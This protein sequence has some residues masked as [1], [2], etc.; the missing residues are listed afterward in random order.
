[1]HKSLD[2]YKPAAAARTH[3]LLAALMWTVVGGSLL[4]VGA[5]W[6]LHAQLAI[7]LPLLA[8]ALTAG[9]L[10]ARFVLRRTSARMIERIRVRGDGRCLGGFVSLQTWAFVILMM[11]LGYLLRHGLLPR[12]VVGFIYVAVGAALLLASRHI[13]SAWQHHQPI[14]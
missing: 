3:L 11:G 9:A 1:M 5:R 7:A 6:A 2:A 14:N 12:T 8:V 4:V 10:K 13:W